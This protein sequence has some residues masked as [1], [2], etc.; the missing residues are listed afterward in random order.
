MKRLNAGVYVLGMCAAAVLPASCGESLP[1]GA[2]SGTP[3]WQ[4]KGLARVA[5]P[6]VI[7]QPTCLALI[8]NDGIEPACSG[9]PCPWKPIDFQT[10]YKLPIS[11]GSGRIV[12]IVDA[13]DNPT[14]RKDLATYRSFYGLGA[15]KFQK[16]NQ[17]GDR[18]NYPPYTG[19]S[20]E[21]DLDIEMVSAACPL[22]TIYLVE[23]NSASSKDLEAAEREAVTLGAHIVSNSWICYASNTCLDKS[24][25]DAPGVTYV[26]S[27]GDAGLDQNGNPESFASVVSVGGT[28]LEKSGSSY[29]ESVWEDAGGGCTNNGGVMGIP[30]PY[31]QHV[32]GCRFRAASDVSAEA[33]CSPGVAEH[34]SFDGGWFEVCGTS[35][36]SPL[37]AAAFA[38]A[39]NAA[40]E[41]AGRTFWTNTHHEYLHRICSYCL[42][43]TYSYGGGWGSPDGIGAF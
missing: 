17:K 22:C 5:C 35:V 13:G 29:S 1:S 43:K 11:K 31:W 23:A 8:A 39:G 20:I 2:A 32:P 36:A 4:A 6:Q 40:K 28:Q 26:A 10:R 9:A 3:Q 33:G 34:D 25:F 24:A 37:M 12:A 21:V 15:A 30:K 18:G 42:F 27:S 41:H 7:G 38:L 14:T 19:W 16:Y